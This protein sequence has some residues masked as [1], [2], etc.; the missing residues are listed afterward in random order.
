MNPS[1]LLGDFFCLEF[2]AGG[3]GGT[4]ATLSARSEDKTFSGRGKE[5]AFSG[6]EDNTLLNLA[7]KYKHSFVS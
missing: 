4:S 2:W 7:V 6:I 3:Y 5:K 1:A